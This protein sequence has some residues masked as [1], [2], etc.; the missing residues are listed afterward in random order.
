MADPDLDEEGRKAILAMVPSDVAG[1]VLEAVG[2][3]G[4]EAQRRGII[5]RALALGGWTAAQ[6]AVE[7]WYT[8]AARKY[9]LR[10]L[11]DYAVD[12]LRRRGELEPGAQAGRWRLTGSGDIV[13]KPLGQVFT[14]AVGVGGEPVDDSWDAGEYAVDHGHIWFAQGS[15]QLSAGDHLF[16]IGASRAG[17]VL[18]LFEVLSSGDLLQPRNPWDPDRWPYAVAVR[19]LAGVPP[20]TATA[21]EGVPTPRATANRV[22]DEQQRL[23]L[24][25]AV[26]G[27][28]VSRSQR[29]Q[30]AAPTG[31]VERGRAL[32]RRRPFE[33]SDS[34]SARRS[35]HVVLAADEIE[36]L[37]EKANAGHH[38]LLV[39]LHS[40]LADAGWS[41][42]HEI[43]LAIDL[44]G[45]DPAGRTTIFEAKTI[46]DSNE[47][48][49]ARGGLAQLLE[50]RQD[51]G[52]PDDRLCLAVD[53]ELNERRRDLLDRLG[54]G[55]A[56]VRAGS[57]VRAL[58]TA[59][60]SALGAS[61]AVG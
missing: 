42:L 28:E 36:D 26:A 52:G 25:A 39:A 49:Q 55:V 60:A 43:P 35:D 54:I 4:G 17:T 6:M 20:V 7:S 16:A 9:H 50:Y 12:V 18:G 30:S 21:V 41:D 11:A 27:H 48:R 58:N 34:P 5:D 14:A 47:I 13:P 61:P 59:G 1:D 10:T 15:N 44:Q 23:G 8:G 46:S 53:R 51:Y 31:L 38:A 22:R 29:D 37:Q 19:A 3:L 32:R 24:Y 33:P 57:E 45:T 56:L 40:H 2:A